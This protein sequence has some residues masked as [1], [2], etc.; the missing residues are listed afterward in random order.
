ML[1]RHRDRKRK[2]NYFAESCAKWRSELRL[3]FDK[4]NLFPLPKIRQDVVYMH[5]AATFGF[6]RASGKRTSHI[7]KH[8]ALVLLTR[9]VLIEALKA[10]GTTDHM[11]KVAV[12]WR[13][14][15]GYGNF[16]RNFLVALSDGQLLLRTKIGRR[17]ETLRGNDVDFIGAHLAD[18]LFPSAIDALYKFKRTGSGIWFPESR[19]E[20]VRKNFPRSREGHGKYTSAYCSCTSP[21]GAMN[22]GFN[23]T[24]YVCQVCR[25]EIYMGA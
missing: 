5:N 20:W 7:P 10:V 12:V 14:T 18:H 2:R 11:D 16:A 1:Q 19:D 3:S 8:K 25:K 9:L 13:H 17:Y 23:S 4:A 21:T 6:N 22:V 15:G 24:L